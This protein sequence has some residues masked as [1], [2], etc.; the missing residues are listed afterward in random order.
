MSLYKITAGPKASGGS[1]PPLA[2]DINQVAK[3]LEGTQDAG[4]LQLAAPVAAPASAPTAVATTGSAL[5]VGAYVYAVTFITGHRR[6]DQTTPVVYETTASPTV[7]VTTTSGNQ[8]VT[9]SSLPVSASASVIGKRIYRTVVGGA[10]RKLVATIANGVTSYVD[11]TPDAS[12]GA[13]EPTTNT[14][15][16]TLAG[17]VPTGRTMQDVALVQTLIQ[18][19][20][21]RTLTMGYTGGQLTTVTEKDGATTVKTTTLGYASGQLTS[22][23]EVVG[24]KTITTT[25]SYNGDGT[26]AS[27]SVVVA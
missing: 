7:A 14:T 12:L 19:V 1:G 22:V 8:A 17:Y 25:L 5:G 9:L 10:Q 18:S 13:N 20:S 11:T 27:T 15:G 16:T 23:T 2:S 4:T 24:G 21:T 3:V 6:D 26:L